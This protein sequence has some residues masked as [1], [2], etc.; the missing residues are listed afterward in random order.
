MHAFVSASI[1]PCSVSVQ[2]R[3]RSTTTGTS[4]AIRRHDSALPS[5]SWPSSRFVIVRNARVPLSIVAQFIRRHVK[6]QPF[7]D[8]LQAP[9]AALH[10]HV[11]VLLD[12]AQPV[13]LRAKARRDDIRSAGR[14][15][16][17]DLDHRLARHPALAP[18][19]REH[20]HA[21]AEQPAQ[22]QPVKPDRQ[23]EGQARQP[24][25]R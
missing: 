23:A 19:M 6:R 14:V 18:D 11:G 5:N 9:C 25:R 21:I 15:V 12:V 13:H 8:R 20:Q 16:P 2:P 4:A 22:P 1:R 10:H 17:H 3:G 7:R 24:T